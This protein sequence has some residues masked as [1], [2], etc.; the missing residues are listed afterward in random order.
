MNVDIGDRLLSAHCRISVV[1]TRI[2]N[3]CRA[4][5]RGE[6]SAER[7]LL[8]LVQDY[9]ENG[10]N[11]KELYGIYQDIKHLDET[12]CRELAP[13]VRELRSNSRTEKFATKICNAL[14][15]SG[16]KEVQL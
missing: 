9:K 2:Y 16:L 14:S 15:N 11:L 3:L 7:A 8:N 1:G 5:G 4:V 13:I 10:D 6:M 12:I